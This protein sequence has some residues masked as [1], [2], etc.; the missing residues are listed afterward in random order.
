MIKI[1]PSVKKILL[2]E[3]NTLTML[4]L[5]ADFQ[6]HGFKV[7]KAADGPS[8]WAACEKENFDLLLIDITLPGFDG[9]E[10]LRKIQTSPSVKQGRAIAM[11]SGLSKKEVDELIQRGFDAYLQ[12]PFKII[13]KGEHLFLEGK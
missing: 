7:S 11:S 9:R 10:L 6:K 2:V 5:E 4:M 1:A 13:K 12:K 8:A 3:D